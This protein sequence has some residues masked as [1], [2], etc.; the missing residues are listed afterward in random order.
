MSVQESGFCDTG[1]LLCLTVVYLACTLACEFHSFLLDLQLSV[2]DLECHLREVLVGVR[3][4][5]CC[6][7]HII[8]A[9]VCC[10]YDVVTVE[11]K[12]VLGVLIVIDT[13]IIAL[14]CLLS[15]VVLVFTAVLCDRYY[16]FCFDRSDFQSSLFFRDLVV[17]SLGSFVQRI[18]EL[19]VGLSYVRYGSGNI[20]CCS[21]S[22]YESVSAHCHVFLCQRCSVVLLAG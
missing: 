18:C 20:V 16:Y 3:E 19:V 6:K 2:H 11:C 13:Y 10:L 22:L 17:F 15:S 12:V 14:H 21:F 8:G 9:C 4:V 1:D 5:F 7:F